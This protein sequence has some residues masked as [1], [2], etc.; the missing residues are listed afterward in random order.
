MRIVF[1]SG[2]AKAQQIELLQTIIAK[3][4]ELGMTF[5]FGNSGYSEA[6]I[7]LVPSKAVT[8][9]EVFAKIQAEALRDEPSVKATKSH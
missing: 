3:A 2:E 4:T 5:E 6:Q 1:D 8:A 7:K 9:G